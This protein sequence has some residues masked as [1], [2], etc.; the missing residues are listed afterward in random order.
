MKKKKK[1]KKDDQ[2]LISD[3]FVMR[4][5]FLLIWWNVFNWS[6]INALKNILAHRI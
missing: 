1:K 6:L 3:D 2:T 5:L 4:D